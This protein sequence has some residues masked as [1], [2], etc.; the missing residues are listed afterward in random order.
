[1]PAEDETSGRLGI[2]Q[3]ARMRTRITVRKSV[4]KGRLRYCRITVE[5][6]K[7]R[8]LAKTVSGQVKREA[9]HP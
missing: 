4:T 6:A 8:E 2:R 1:M 7:M 3:L 5:P 9:S